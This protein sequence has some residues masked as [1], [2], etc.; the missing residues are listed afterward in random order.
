MNHPLERAKHIIKHQSDPLQFVK[1]RIEW[2]HH[3][4]RNR[5]KNREVRYWVK[6]KK[7]VVILLTDEFKKEKK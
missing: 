1:D 3:Y 7:N 4:Q 5:N 6:I 2:I